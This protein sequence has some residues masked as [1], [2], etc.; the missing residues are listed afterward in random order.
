[1]LQKY[2]QLCVK[3]WILFLFQ[4][5]FQGGAV[6]RCQMHPVEAVFRCQY[7]GLGQIV[8][9]HHFAFFFRGI[10]KFPGSFGGGCIVQVKNSND[11][12]VPDRHIIADGKIHGYTPFSFF[13][14]LTASSSQ[15]L[16][17][18]LVA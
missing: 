6:E 8:T 11:G 16:F 15:R 12:L 3:L 5:F 13:H 17:L 10:Q 4:S 7:K 9:G 14:S 2:P 18:G 1:M